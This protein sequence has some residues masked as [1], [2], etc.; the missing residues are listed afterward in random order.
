MTRRSNLT[1]LA[2]LLSVGLLITPTLRGDDKERKTYT[3]PPK[4][5][6]DVNKTYTA[7]IETAKGKIVCELYPKEAP[8]TVEQ[9]RLPRPGGL[10]TM[11]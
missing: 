7:T 6:I 4:M 3:E 2:C 5:T 8:E 10:F 9:L 11:G 1:A